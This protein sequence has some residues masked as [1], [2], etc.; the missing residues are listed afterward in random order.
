VQLA[1]IVDAIS[2]ALADALVADF[3]ADSLDKLTSTVGSP[4]GIDHPEG[5]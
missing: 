1:E 2:D 5:Q 4:S 3:L